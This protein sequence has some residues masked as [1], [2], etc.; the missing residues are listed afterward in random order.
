LAGHVARIWEKRNPYR[1]LGE[2]A[3][4]KETGRKTKT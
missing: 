2:K 3:R 1:L 4:G